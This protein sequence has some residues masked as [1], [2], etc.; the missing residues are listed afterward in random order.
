MNTNVD[1][2]VGVCGRS[3]WTSIGRGR[4]TIYVCVTGRTG[5]IKSCSI[6][7]L[8]W[9]SAALG[10]GGSILCCTME[11]SPYN[12]CSTAPSPYTKARITPS[13]EENVIMSTHFPSSSVTHEIALCREKGWCAMHQ[14]PA[15]G[16]HP[17][18]VH[19]KQAL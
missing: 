11:R 14:R 17:M 18:S 7:H 5:G 13:L 2:C 16:P 1:K 19:H 3:S 10:A 15:R 9:T 12:R 8:Q 6:V 4:A